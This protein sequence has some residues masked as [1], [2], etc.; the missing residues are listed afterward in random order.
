MPSRTWF[1]ATGVR[2]LPDGLRQRAAHRALLARP[3]EE[4]QGIACTVL[5]P[6]L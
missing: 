3:G 1:G 4:A 5:L 2:K 6:G